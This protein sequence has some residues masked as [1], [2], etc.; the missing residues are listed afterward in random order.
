MIL[1]KNQHWGDK[2][3]IIEALK[4]KD[5]NNIDNKN[6]I[7]LDRGDKIKNLDSFTNG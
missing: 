7:L 6:L 5:I 3:S 4:L 1:G 2:K